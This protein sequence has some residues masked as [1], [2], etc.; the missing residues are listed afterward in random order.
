MKA[1]IRHSLQVFIVYMRMTL[2]LMCFFRFLVFGD[3]KEL[4]QNKIN[5]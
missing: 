1:S 2:G 5:P 4:L 3:N